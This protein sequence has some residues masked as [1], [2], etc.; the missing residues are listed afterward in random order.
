MEVRKILSPTQIAGGSFW[1]GPIATVYYLR[2]N[3]I[4]LGKVDYAQKTLIYGI[5]FLT[6]L[7]G[8]IPFL[9]EKFPNLLIPMIYCL[10][11]KQIAS[12]TQME[13]EQIEQSEE[14]TFESNWKILGVGIL[15]LLLFMII[16][17]VV[18]FLL[19]A[20]GLVILA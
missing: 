6:C 14:Y 8:I 13:K 7:L 2:K 5:I 18:M 3:Y 11:A 20:S 10:S 17:I 15:T 19:D 4:S 9:P 12:A 1:G 16:A